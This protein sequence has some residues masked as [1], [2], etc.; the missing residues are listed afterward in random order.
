[1][2]AAGNDPKNPTPVAARL[3]LP[4]KGKE[5]FNPLS[6]FLHFPLPEG[7]VEHLFP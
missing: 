5:D 6:V 2:P 7:R 3:A 1:M 4:M